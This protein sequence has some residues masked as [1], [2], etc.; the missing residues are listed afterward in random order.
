[1]RALPVA[2][3]LPLSAACLCAETKLVLNKVSAATAFDSPQ[4]TVPA[5]ERVILTTPVVS[6]DVW[7]KD[8]RP[9]PDGLG[10][11]LVIEAARP[12]DSGRYRVSYVSDGITESQELQLTVLGL[13]GVDTSPRMR[14]FTTRGIAGAGA[15]SLVAGFVVS[16]SPGNPTATKRVLVRAVGPT[17]LEFG[18]TNFLPDPRLHVYDANGN[19][20]EPS[21]T[22]SLAIADAHLK[23]GAFPLKPGATDAVQILTLKPGSYTA[24]VSAPA[25]DV[26]GLVILDVNEI[27]ADK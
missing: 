25:A 22:D 18:I 13:D 10:P 1:M 20:C 11:V 5:G 3:L 6:G 2:L 27:P 15:Q 23:T 16:E 14:T 4:I 9:V 12:S 26:T 8:G 24:Q 21:S 19:A 17:L 7:L